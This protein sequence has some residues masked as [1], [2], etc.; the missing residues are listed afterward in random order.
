MSCKK[1]RVSVNLTHDEHK[2]IEDL[3]IQ[4]DVSQSWV[5]RKAIQEYLSK[6]A[7]NV[8]IDS[9]KVDKECL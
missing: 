7:L 5:I 4:L 2:F 8:Q 1:C 9:K 6:A 3:S